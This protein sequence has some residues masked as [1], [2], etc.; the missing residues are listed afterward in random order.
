MFILIQNARVFSPGDLGR[1]DVLI[2]N[3]RIIRIAEHIDFA[4]QGDDLQVIDGTGKYLVPGFI[5]Q[6]V[7]MIGG[8]GEDGFASL[9]RE[10]QM[11]DCI[12]AGVTT[13]VGL[14]GTD[15]HA[16]S[17]AALVAR[18]KGLKEQ[19][20]SAYC[21]TGSY[22]YPTHTLTGSVDGDIAFV[23]EII[24]VKVAISDQRS[25]NISAEELA[26]LATQARTAG[27]LAGKPGYVHMHTGSGKKGYS[28]VVRIINETDLPVWQ[29]RP[30]HFDFSIPG[31]DEF[32]AMGGYADFTTGTDTAKTAERL[33]NAMNRMRREQMT[34]SSDS[35][36][37]FPQWGEDGKI[38]GMGIGRMDTLY[39]T[40][41]HLIID[42]HVNIGDALSLI[43][44]N[45][46]EA[47]MLYPRKGSISEGADADA[48]LLDQDLQ[49]DTVI[50]LGR[51]MM[52]NGSLCA[53]NYY[54]Y[55]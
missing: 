11:T 27:L 39:D 4:W 46:A 55:E 22:A 44:S 24:G 36:G 41:R 40:I 49:I 1:R 30:T 33:Y 45:V 34:L 53:D 14:L 28:D 52:Q 32:V 5:D 10:I 31:A 25:S 43:T 16:K 12:R 26:R 20:M 23:D 38:I 47:L 35:N 21:L 15:H 37:S 50:A 54:H 13:A 6:H 51:I 9:I 18:T 29:F 48:V 2:C 42:H 17:V 8:G 3:D 19:G 7:H